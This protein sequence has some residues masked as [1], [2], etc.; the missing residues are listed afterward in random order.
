[1][2]R[3]SSSQVPDEIVLDSDTD[4]DDDEV[5]VVSEDSSSSDEVSGKIN[6]NRKLFEVNAVEVEN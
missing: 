1:M 6:P 5:V 3:P 4:L 2:D